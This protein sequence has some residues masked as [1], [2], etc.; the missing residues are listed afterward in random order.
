M[1]VLGFDDGVVRIMCVNLDIRYSGERVTLLQSWKPHRLAV[2][3]MSIN[4]RE[5]VLV[6]GSE[7]KTVFMHQIFAQEP[8]VTFLPIG[9]VDL[10]SAATALNWKPNMVSPDK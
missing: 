10:P 5:S 3:V 6:T 8:F 9:F 7:D 4:P 2:T 1:L